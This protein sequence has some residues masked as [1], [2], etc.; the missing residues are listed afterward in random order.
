MLRPVIVSL[1][2]KRHI[3]LPDLFSDTKRLVWVVV[4][5]GAPRLAYAIKNYLLAFSGLKFRYYMGLSWPI[6]LFSR[7]ALHLSREIGRGHER[8]LFVE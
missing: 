3:E 1:L 8:R 4:F 6:H 5:L 7:A 2:V